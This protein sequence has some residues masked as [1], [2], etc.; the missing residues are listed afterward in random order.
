MK[1]ILMRHGQTDYNL[2]G[3]NMGRRLDA[4]INATGRAQIEQTIPEVKLL[5]PELIIASPMKRTRES[6]EIIQQALG[7]PIEF[8]ERIMEID[9]G[10]ISGETK[11]EASKLMGLSLEG[12]LYQYRIGQY[13]YTEFGGESYQD[14]RNRAE[15]FL[16]DLRQRK[17]QCVIIMCHGG[18]VRSLHN[19]ITGEL[20]LVDQGIPNAVVMILEYV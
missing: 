3:I 5:N 9:T 2:A 8:D 19:L 16:R 6:A 7:I 13:D 15:S 4:S 17:E 11:A 1:I 10:S 14:I 18:L 12:A 20:S